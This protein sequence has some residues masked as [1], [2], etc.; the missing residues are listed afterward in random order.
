MQ[1]LRINLL[2]PVL[3]LLTA[4]G[5]TGYHPLSQTYK[6]IQVDSVAAAADSGM[7]QLLRPYKQRLDQSMNEVL[8]RSTAR[9]AQGKPEGPL[10]DLLTD[11]L[12]QQAIK[13]Y[14]KPIDCSHLNYH[15]IRNSLPQGTITTG[16][17]FE[18]MP[19]DNQMVVLTLKGDVLKGFL[20]HFA[21]HDEALVVG[22]MRATLHNNKILS[23][24]FTNGRPLEP[25][26]TYTI[27][28]SD[29][30]ANGGDDTGLTKA[31]VLRRDDLNFLIRDA[32]IEAL[33]QQGKTG[34]PLTPTTDGRI[35][36]Q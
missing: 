5:R 25:S 24:T 3:A 28:I 26:Q 33:R 6:R 23:A 36:I 31:N 10:N 7:T 15:G 14:G 22:G 8:T 19:F 16:A 4:C 11:I 17:V 20:E 29:Y 35:T 30:V 18:V 32:F 34:Q 27:V 21:E 2:I 12:L 9:L 1:K 13:Q